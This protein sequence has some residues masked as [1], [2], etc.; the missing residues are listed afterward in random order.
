LAGISLEAVAFNHDPASHD[1]DALN[2]RW[3]A[4]DPLVVPEWRRGTSVRPQDSAAAYAIREIANKPITIRAKFSTQDLGLKRVQ[5]RAVLDP[6]LG[7]YPWNVTPNPPPSNTLP[8]ALLGGTPATPGLNKSALGPVAAREIEF[9][10]DGDTDLELFELREHE[11]GRYGVGVHPLNWWWQYQ[12]SDSPDWV[13]FALSQHIIFTVLTTPTLPWQQDDYPL[14][15]QLP[16]VEVLNAACIWARGTVSPERAAARVTEAVFQLGPE[17]IEY[18]CPNL[19][20]P[21]YT[22]PDWDAGLDTFNCTAFLERLNGG[23][24]RGVYVNCSDCAAIVSTFANSLGCDL[25]Q[26]RMGMLSQGFTINPIL[27]IGSQQWTQPCGWWP[28]FGMHEV[29]WTGACSDD[30]A[31]FDACLAFD[32]DYDPARPPFA[33][34]LPTNMRFGRAGD[35]DYRDHLARLASRDD[36]PSQPSTRQRRRVI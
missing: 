23:Y 17:I 11:I 15:T 4:R 14:N 2:L 32:I 25:W 7:V 34:H 26:S 29:A 8:P 31:V 19:G 33:S 18:N 24:G 1:H 21:A 22:S 27:A 35:G 3:N 20:A 9:D 6:S 10:A 28:G 30:N 13:T 5:V 36:C 16:W 12:R